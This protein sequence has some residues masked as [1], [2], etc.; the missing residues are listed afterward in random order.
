VDL[1]LT[2]A[3][4]PLPRATKRAKQRSIGNPRLQR[5]RPLYWLDSE[6]VEE[7]NTACRH[8]RSAELELEEVM[9]C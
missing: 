7:L 4:V 1:K 8:F 9:T 6:T 2:E 5:Q 3:E